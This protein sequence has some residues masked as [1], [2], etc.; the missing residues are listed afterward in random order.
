MRGFAPSLVLF[1]IVTVAATFGL[2]LVEAAYGIGGG[3]IQWHHLGPLI[4]AAV[5]SMV[6]PATSRPDPPEPVA[7]RQWIAHTVLGVVAAG[8]FAALVFAGFTMLQVP[9]PDLSRAGLGT[10]V[11]AMLGLA[12]GAIAQEIGWRGFLQPTLEARTSRMGAAVIVGLVWTLW[13]ITAYTDLVTAALL[14]ATYLPLAVLLAHLGNGSVL[15]R[16]IT[17]SIVHWLVTLP[18]MLLAGIGGSVV[19]AVVGAATVIVTA[20]F[21]L[22]FKIATGRRR[23]RA[24]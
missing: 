21:M 1:L 11:I 15:Q 20:V 10:V 2:R 5:T 22:M 18:V 3:A 4:G 7:R 23:A 14:L 9:A 6:V 12:V 24:S 19:Q 16:V 17:T 13:H 8:L